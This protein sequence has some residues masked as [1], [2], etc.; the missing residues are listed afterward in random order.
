MKKILFIAAL[1][2]SAQAFANQHMPVPTCTHKVS[3]TIYDSAGNVMDDTTYTRNWPLD[4]FTST[5]LK[6]ETIRK[7]VNNGEAQFNALIGETPTP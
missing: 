2:F 5:K 3:Y 1:M 4:C 7:L 6:Y